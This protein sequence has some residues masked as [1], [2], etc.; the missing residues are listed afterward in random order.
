MHHAKDRLGERRAQGD[1]FRHRVIGYL[2]I[3]DDVPPELVDAVFEE[4]VVMG[5]SRRRKAALDRLGERV[6]RGTSLR[7]SG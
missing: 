5:S 7:Q 6:R 1:R 4:L 2:R 3:G